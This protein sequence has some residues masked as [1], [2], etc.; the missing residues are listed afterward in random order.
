MPL[1]QS[2]PHF[3]VFDIETTGFCFGHDDRILEV[4]VVRLDGSGNLIDEFHTL[5]NPKRDVGSS[6]T[7][8]IKAK[9]VAHAP[10]FKD[11]AGDI[12]LRARDAIIVGHNVVYDVNFLRAELK[13]LGND[14]SEPAAICTLELS[15]NVYPQSATRR[16]SNICSEL[17]LPLPYSHAAIDDARATGQ[18]LKHLLNVM[19]AGERKKLLSELPPP[20]PWPDVPPSGK[21][22]LR[23]PAGKKAKPS[24]IAA[25]VD[26]LPSVNDVTTQVAKYLELLDRVLRDRT[27]TPAEAKALTD[28]ARELGIEREQAQ[29]AHERYLHDLIHVA[30]ADG[31][32]TTQERSDIERV[33]VELG[34]PVD[35]FLSMF[36]APPTTVSHKAIRKEKK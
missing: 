35:Q 19:P 3:A 8:G 6:G 10:E 14:V 24:Y 28:L 12:A 22:V 1:L 7:H 26:K 23:Q 33:R 9:D 2:T 34:I 11:V 30:L 17:N 27:I 20:W 18:L 32:L 5:L 21:S 13:R 16:L 15:R 25:L 4:A 31:H 36:T 29:V